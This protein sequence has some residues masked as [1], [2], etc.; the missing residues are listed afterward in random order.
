VEGRGYIESSPHILSLGSPSS[1]L[2]VG[3]DSF[4]GLIATDA[5]LREEISRHTWRCGGRGGRSLFRAHS[6]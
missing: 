1:F 4:D 6:C 3:D 5:R 2:P